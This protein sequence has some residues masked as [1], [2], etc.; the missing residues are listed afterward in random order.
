MAQYVVTQLL[1]IQPV[2]ATS[3]RAVLK[4]ATAGP[5]TIVHVGN[6]SIEDYDESEVMD[7][8]DAMHLDME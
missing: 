3:M 1:I 5:G 8:T 4:A 6:T 2:T 7:M